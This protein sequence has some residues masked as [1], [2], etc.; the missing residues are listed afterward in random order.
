M[1]KASCQVSALPS[2]GIGGVMGMA[3]PLSQLPTRSAQLGSERSV[4]I[5]AYSPIE[6]F[7]ADAA[8]ISA[9]LHSLVLTPQNN[10][11]DANRPFPTP[12][13]QALMSRWPSGSDLL[14]P[15]PKPSRHWPSGSL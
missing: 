7:S 4:G 15:S 3:W 1:R 12:L 11:Q 6:L 8:R 2:V 13:A 10:F 5:S 9:A 14:P